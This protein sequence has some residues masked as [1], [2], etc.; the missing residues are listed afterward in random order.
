MIKINLLPVK[1][2]KKKETAIQQ[3][4]VAGAVLV[5]LAVAVASLYMV[6]RSQVATARRDITAANAKINELKAKLGKLEEIKKLKEEVKKKLDVL[7]QLRKN[8]TGPAQRLVV[9]SDLTPEQLWLTSYVESNQDVKI[10]GV[11]YT[12]DLIAHFMKALE[13]SRN[14]MAVELLLSEQT[15]AG[16][17]K[18]KKF[19]LTLK[20]RPDSG[21]PPAVTPAAGK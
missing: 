3:L 21:Q 9:L 15:E 19:D 4:I 17:A 16:G 1:T 13:S 11:A 8:K 18:L 2:S 7:I 10:S 12:E 6:K 14:F 20:L 5:V